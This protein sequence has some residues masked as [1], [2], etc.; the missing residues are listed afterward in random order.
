[1]WAHQHGKVVLY[2]VHRVTHNN[3]G[4]ETE[5]EREAQTLEEGKFGGGHVCWKEGEW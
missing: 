2:N 3:S 1:M 4:E 5:R